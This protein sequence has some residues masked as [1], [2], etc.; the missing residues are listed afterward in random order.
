MSVAVERVPTDRQRLVLSEDVEETSALQRVPPN[1]KQRV[2]L[3]SFESLDRGDGGICGGGLLEPR[4][5]PPRTQSNGT[6]EL[7]PNTTR[8]NRTVTSGRASISSSRTN[9]PR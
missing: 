4:G 8:S 2:E 1:T 7:R 5:S 6:S 3:G 9:S